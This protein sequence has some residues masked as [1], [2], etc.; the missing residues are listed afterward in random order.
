MYCGEEEHVKK[1]PGYLDGG[2]K[3]KYVI[4]KADGSRIDP[5]AVYFVLRLD[6]DPNARVAAAAYAASVEEAGNGELA[7]DIRL[8]LMA[9]RG[10]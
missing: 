8:R 4:A 5:K 9:Y 6:K 2:W 7:R 10:K 1:K 3:E